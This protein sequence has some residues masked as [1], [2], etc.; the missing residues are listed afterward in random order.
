MPTN[1]NGHK[2]ADLNHK[3]FDRAFLAWEELKR[4]LSK[5]AKDHDCAK[6]LAE[7]VLLQLGIKIKVIEV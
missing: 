1:P 3:S 5:L 4:E 6:G 7:E 2:I